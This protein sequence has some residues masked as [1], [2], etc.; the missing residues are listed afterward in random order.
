MAVDWV[1][2]KNRMVSGRVRGILG[3]IVSRRSFNTTI[4]RRPELFPAR[5][6]WMRR[7]NSEPAINIGGHRLPRLHIAERPQTD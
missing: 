3:A 7:L 5:L 4:S 6:L 1:R 2:K